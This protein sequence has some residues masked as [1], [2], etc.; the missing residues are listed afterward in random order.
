[1]GQAFVGA[2]QAS[3]RIYEP[4]AEDSIRFGSFIP[5]DAAGTKHRN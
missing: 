2:W 3:A 1:M 4:L 5:E